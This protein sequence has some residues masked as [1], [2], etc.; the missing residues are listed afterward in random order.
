MAVSTTNLF[1]LMNECLRECGE[2]PFDPDF[3]EDPTDNTRVLIKQCIKSALHDFAREANWLFL[4]EFRTA[5]NWVLERA[6]IGSHNRLFQVQ[7]RQQGI[8]YLPEISIQN[9][10]SI[11]LAPGSVPSCFA[12][13]NDAEVVLYPYPTTTLDRNSVQFLV[14]ANLV[15]PTIEAG[16]FNMPEEMLGVFKLKVCMHIALKHLGNRETVQNFAGMYSIALRDAIN[17]NDSRSP[18]AAN[19]F[20]RGR[21]YGSGYR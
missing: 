4:R 12:I 17:T 14:S 1:T 5:T 9:F 7:Y 16:Y 3:D 2:R 18:N 21:S 10:Y 19:M 11:A 20:Q 13:L 6:D 15:M 8:F